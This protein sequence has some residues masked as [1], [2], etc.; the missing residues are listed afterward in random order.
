MTDSL[1]A[2]L[3]KKYISYRNFLNDEQIVT[4]ID[5]WQ[6]SKY[7]RAQTLQ[8][9]ARGI[10]D[11]ICGRISSELA[12]AK[13]VDKLNTVNRCQLDSWNPLHNQKV[14]EYFPERFPFQRFC[15]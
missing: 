8:D 15:I 2:R 1:Q 9:V 3:Y 4:C 14:N 7:I 12:L 5:E 13:E 11:K 6:R 10:V